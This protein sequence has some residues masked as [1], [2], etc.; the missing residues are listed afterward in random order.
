[1]ATVTSRESQVEPLSVW[2]RVLPAVAIVL[3]AWACAMEFILPASHDELHYS[4]VAW[5]WSQGKEPYRDFFYPNTPGII[6]MLGAA[7]LMLGDF[8]PEVLWWGRALC[9]V[10]LVTV[11]GFV[12]AIGRTVHSR[13]AG[14]IAVILFVP[15]MVIPWAGD[16]LFKHHF[17]IRPEIFAMPWMTAAVW[18]GFLAIKHPDRW[19]TVRDGA[20]LSLLTAAA[21]FLTPRM[22]FMAA[23]LGVALAVGLGRRIVPIALGSLAGLVA[24][25]V[26]YGGLIGWEISWTWVYQYSKLL[27]GTDRLT[28]L[29]LLRG[30]PAFPTVVF[31]P[32]AGL[33]A[34]IWS[35]DRATRCLAWMVLAMYSNVLI[36]GRATS[37][38]WRGHIVVGSALL[39]AV[40]YEWFSRPSH[41]LRVAV[42]L[43]G[44][45]IIGLP[46]TEASTRH[47]VPTGMITSAGWRGHLV[48]GSAL[49]AAVGYEWFSRPSRALRVAVVLIGLTI[50]GLPLSRFLRDSARVL[51]CGRCQLGGQIAAYHRVCAATRGEPVMWRQQFHPIAVD[52]G[53]YLWTARGTRPLMVRLGIPER[54]LDVLQDVRERPPVILAPAE[55]RY[56]GQS[57]A[58]R[59]WIDSFVAEN[60]RETEHGFMVRKEQFDKLAPLL[61]EFGVRMHLSLIRKE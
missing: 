32:L 43:I 58:D 22:I 6:Y 37:A 12:L 55:L 41:A 59:E 33:V 23:G 8:G 61:E 15:G 4:H 13:R 42:V 53:T 30:N 18:L 50:I 9:V 14:W 31:A 36:E 35:R 5:L 40:G 10:S 3:L 44:L 54:K 34:V 47:M 25:V 46:L 17:E 27:V 26:L 57:S 11:A 51:T 20:L 60:Y 24:L 52:D 45:T 19:A 28:Y 21:M 56:G 49:L 38:S 2:D 39:A 29:T 1:M 16:L 7:R 48:V